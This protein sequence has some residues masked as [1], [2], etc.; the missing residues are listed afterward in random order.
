MAWVTGVDVDRTRAGADEW[1]WSVPVVG[2]LDQLDL[3]QPVTFLVGENGSGKS[4]I[5]ES[6][7][8]ACGCPRE[9][10]PANRWCK[11]PT[12]GFE[13]CLSPRWVGGRT[14]SN[15]QFLRAETYFDVASAAQAFQ[16]G[17]TMDYA[18][19]Q[20]S[21]SFDGE[22]PLARSHGQ[23]FLGLF[24][25]RMEGQSL[26]FM[27]EPEAALSVR[28]SLGLIASMHDLVEAGAQLVIAT[29]SPVLLAYPGATIYELSDDGFHVK[30]WEETALVQDTRTFLDGPERYLRHLF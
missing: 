22:S 27:D 11:G 7:A 6:L 10:G 12:W 13:S 23:G 30:A 2:V 17:T 16:A 20:L 19:A 4:T 1:Q 8:V 28:S 29:H 9:G 15:A 3:D 18:A 5:V 14:P 21:E 25:S 26:W 24:T